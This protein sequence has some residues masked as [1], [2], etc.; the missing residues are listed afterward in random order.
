MAKKQ[1]KK[2]NVKKEGF[3]KQVKSE[4]KK[5]KWPTRKDMIKYSITTLC[6]IVLFALFFYIITVLFSLLKGMI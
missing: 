1:N 3:L 5:V 4:M 2:T 6:F